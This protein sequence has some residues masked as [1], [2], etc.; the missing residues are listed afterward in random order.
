[1]VPDSMPQLK[2]TLKNARLSQAAHDLVTRFVIAFVL[3]TGRMSCLAAAEALRSEPRHRAQLARFTARPRW[4]EAELNAAIRRDLLDME[5]LDGTFVFIVDAT[6]V[7]QAGQ[8]TQNTHSTGNRTRRPAT[9]RR[10]GKYKHAAKRC[11]SFTMG[12]LITPSGLRLPYCQPYHTLEYCQRKGLP[13]RTTAEAAADLIRDLPVE[14]SDTTRVVVLGDTAYEAK[15]VQQACQAKHYTW[16]F[17]CNPER[18][19]AG[20]QGSRRK[21]RSLLAEWSSKALRTIKVAPGQ[22]PFAVY[23]RVSPHRIGPKAKL[24]TYDATQ[25]TRQVHSVGEVQLVFSTKQADLHIATPDHVKI[26]MTNDLHLSLREI[27]ELYSLRWQVELLFKE[28]KSTLGLDHYQFE[29]FAS[30]EGWVELALT[31]FMYLERYR[32]LQL[33]RDD[34]SAEGKKW[35]RHQRTHG[36]C[37][38]VRLASEQEELAYLAE[39]LKTPA[40]IARLRQVIHD[41]FAPEYRAKLRTTEAHH[42]NLD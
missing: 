21:V 35:W 42:V 29:D 22:G 13:H 23:R 7:S 8:R 34:L 28:L 16:I 9:G 12:V 25:E 14:A 30:V 32:A 41:S 3:H 38:A 24:Q 6:L 33:A 37:Q 10:Y 18:M 20:P 27:L 31:S 26:L 17:P 5:R 11:H 15:V 40:G 19:L 36:L 2:S 1:M 4:K 39:Q